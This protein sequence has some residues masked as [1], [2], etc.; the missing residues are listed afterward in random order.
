[1]FKFSQ[2]DIANLILRKNIA[3]QHQNF[4]HC[5]NRYA[6]VKYTM[7]TPCT[8]LARVPGYGAS[9]SVPA[10]FVHDAGMSTSRPW[11]APASLALS[12]SL[13]GCYVALSK[14]LV[15]ALPVFVLAWLRF[16][17][18]GLAMAHWL[19]RP[20]NEPALTARTR[21]LLFLESFLGNFLFTIC[22]LYGMR[23]TSASAAGVV[24]AAIPAAVAVLS[25][26]FLRERLGQR[27]GMAIALAALGIGLFSL[28]KPADMV[29]AGERFAGLPMAFW[30]N[31]LIMAAV[32]CEAAYVV[33]GKHLT[34]G[35]GPR[36]ISAL[37]NLWGLALVTPLAWWALP[38]V[39]WS[40][41]SAPLW[42]LLLFYALAAS[43]WTVW[44]WM[45]GLKGI[46]ASEAGV[47]TVMLPV[48][49]TVV[50]VVFMGERLS[51]L[52][53][54]AL[55][56]ALLGLWLATRPARQAH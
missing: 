48:S 23:L 27:Q 6:A 15:A 35:L 13:V 19:R 2:Y 47:Y 31:A 42:G 38:G 18:G 25:A 46:P 3:M 30:G 36:R 34:Q 11:W 49:A 20:A 54:L 41:M 26:V 28:G 56:I 44:L 17:I 32:L 37:I 43:V 50:G 55:G 5:K 16:A 22:M 12:M 39:D 24:M 4:S 29:P 7:R 14:P 45:T 33:I 21:W 1:M 40:A 51:A 52:Q 9:Q 10:R 8:I 53:G